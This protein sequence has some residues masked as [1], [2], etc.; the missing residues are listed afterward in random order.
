VGV[1]IAIV[2]VVLLVTHPGAI[3]AILRAVGSGVM[4]LAGLVALWGLLC[5]VVSTVAVLTPL[6]LWQDRWLEIAHGVLA[7]ILFVGCGGLLTV[8]GTVLEKRQR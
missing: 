2:V 1:I 5:I 8:I 7:A 3:G 6:D 4:A